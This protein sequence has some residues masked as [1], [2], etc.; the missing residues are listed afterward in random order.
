MPTLLPSGIS[1][2]LFILFSFDAIL[3]GC[4]LENFR[5]RYI[6]KYYSHH[7]CLPFGNIPFSPF[8]LHIFL[9]PFDSVFWGAFTRP[10]LQ[11]HQLLCNIFQVFSVSALPS[12]FCESD[13]FLR[14]SLFFAFFSN[15]L[16]LRYSVMILLLVF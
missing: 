14:C 12:V 9:L 3:W 1:P 8:L 2:D 13:T 11:L 16:F 7:C 5:Y 4:Y 6:A 10:C 15:C